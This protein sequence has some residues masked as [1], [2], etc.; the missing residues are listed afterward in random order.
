MCADGWDIAPD[1]AAGESWGECP[2]CG[3]KVVLYCDGDV[4]AATGCN[5][6]PMQCDLCGSSP[7][8]QSC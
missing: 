1:T 8:D 7:C 6:S 3:A 2:E 4:V 5:Y